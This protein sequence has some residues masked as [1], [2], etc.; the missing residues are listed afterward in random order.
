MVSISSQHGDRINSNGAQHCRQGSLCCRGDKRNRGQEAGR[1]FARDYGVQY[2]VIV[3]D[4]SEPGFLSALTRATS[5]LDIGL[6]ISNAETGNPGEFLA[7]D[8][9]E[10]AGL[11][12]L[13]SF[14][15]ME[16]AHHFGRRLAERG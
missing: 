1:E 12:R 14:A 4:L 16:I 6:I 2:R 3:A 9:D 7:L 10:M 8:C 11:M 13:N 5:D 15:H